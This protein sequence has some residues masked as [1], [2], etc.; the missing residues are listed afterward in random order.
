[1]VCLFFWVLDPHPSTLG[2]YNFLN[3][4]MFFLTISSAPNTLIRWVQV[5][6]NFHAK[7][8]FHA[9]NEKSHCG[10][11]EPPF[12][13]CKLLHAWDCCCCGLHWI[14]V[15]VVA[16]AA[17]VETAPQLALFYFYLWCGVL[18]FI[19]FVCLFFF[20]LISSCWFFLKF[21]W[22]IMSKSSQA[23]IICTY[24]SFYIIMSWVISQFCFSMWKR[25]F[26]VNII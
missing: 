22:S 21:C 18:I 26:K 8:N 4:N 16:A 24:I 13:S 9:I 23:C 6:F 7:F 20:P 10:V 3:S 17:I 2:G 11:N 19:L 25:D 5:L 1:M 14:A 12:F 15:V